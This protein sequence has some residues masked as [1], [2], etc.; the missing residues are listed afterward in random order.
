MPGCFDVNR[1]IRT[2]VLMGNIINKRGD[3]AAGGE[4]TGKRNGKKRQA[5]VHAWKW[6]KA[7]LS[8]L[9]IV[10][11]LKRFTR[12]NVL[13]AILRLLQV[14]SQANIEKHLL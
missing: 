14:H 10:E 11:I 5:S 2:L 6:N 9:N 3:D 4:K 12:K 1:R 8:K 13:S 7:T